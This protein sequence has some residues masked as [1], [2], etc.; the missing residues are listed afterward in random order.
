MC[1]IDYV[2]SLTVV[3]L[4]LVSREHHGDREPD[5]GRA[6]GDQHHSLSIRCHA[7]TGVTERELR[8]GLFSVLSQRVS[9]R[10]RARI[11]QTAELHV[12]L[13]FIVMIK[14]QPKKKQ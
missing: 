12:H 3:A 14:I 13:F 2:S 10:E 4:H 5:T 9:A 8:A 11:T 6:A 1:V 7:F